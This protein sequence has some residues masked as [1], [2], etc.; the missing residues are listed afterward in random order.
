MFKSESFRLV[1][2]VL[3]NILGGKKAWLIYIILFLDTYLKE[4][5]LIDKKLV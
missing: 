4:R 1:Y 5:K 3:S 2:S